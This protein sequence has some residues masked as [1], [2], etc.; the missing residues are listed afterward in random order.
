MSRRTA[1]P[2]L[3]GIGGAVALAV[4]AALGWLVRRPR[5]TPARSP[6]E[7]APWDDEPLTPEDEAAIVQS[8]AEV[9]R[10]ESLTLPE[11]EATLAGGKD[12]G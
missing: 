11:L 5:R 1:D 6:S 9:A 8:E 3:A 7:N 4:A 10:G 2:R 12:S